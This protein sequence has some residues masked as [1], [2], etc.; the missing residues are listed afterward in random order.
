MITNLFIFCENTYLAQD[1]LYITAISLSLE[2]RLEIF[3]VP[4]ITRLNKNIKKT[5]DPIV[6]DKLLARKQTIIDSISINSKFSQLNTLAIALPSTV[7][8]TS[9]A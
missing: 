5:I 6:V 8:S 2:L 7:S 9:L 3:N 1:S 4:L